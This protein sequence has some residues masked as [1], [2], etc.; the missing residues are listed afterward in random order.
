MAAQDV[1]DKVNRVLPELPKDI[2]QPPVEKMDPDATP[3]LTIAVSAPAAS[4]TSPSI[5]TRCCAASWRRS[6]GVGQVMLVGGQA[7]QI[8]VQLDPMK[9]RAYKLTV[10]DV[11]R[12]L[13]RRTSRCPAAR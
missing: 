4:A 8:N 2:E 3:I 11:A 1:R 6:N 10:A 5:A 13:Q 7:R 9:L 12:A